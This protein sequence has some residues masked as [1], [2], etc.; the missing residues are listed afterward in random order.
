MIVIQKET[1]VDGQMSRLAFVKDRE[2]VIETPSQIKE[3]ENSIFKS[4]KQKELE[5]LEKAGLKTRK[6]QRKVERM[7]LRGKSNSGRKSREDVALR[8]ERKE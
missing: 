5:R 3:I 2:K 7:V 8:K 6:L 1:P 4:N